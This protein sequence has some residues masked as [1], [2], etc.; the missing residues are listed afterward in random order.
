[1]KTVRISETRLF[2]SGDATVGFT[3]T[4]V[5]DGAYDGD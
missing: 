1:M 3:M 4:T 5:S 2:A